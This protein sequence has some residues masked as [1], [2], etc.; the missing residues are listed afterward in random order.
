MLRGLTAAIAL[1]T[2]MGAAGA[3]VSVL[4]AGPP[5]PR[6][7][8]VVPNVARD[9]LAPSRTPYPPAL[10][11]G[12]ILAPVDKEHELAPECAP[13]DL[14]ALDPAHAY[15]AQL[16]RREAAEA[17]ERMTRAAAAAGLW[18]GASSAYRSYQEQII[19]FDYWVSV[20]GIEQAER[21]SARPGHSEHQLGT[22]VDLCGTAG[23]LE[24]FDGTPEA[25]WVAVHAGSYGFVVS[26]SGEKEAVTGY[27]G[28]AWHVRYVGVEVAR[29]VE[30][31]GLTLHEFLLR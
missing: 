22:T 4:A 11:C 10:T 27:A 8:I 23:C 16:L 26:Y 3:A 12:D 28:E 18:I 14:V 9:G 29:A 2:V 20:L 31:S 24:A 1:A 13:P 21:T 5:A 7:R 30:A 17:F 6:P 25:A 19:T 15:G